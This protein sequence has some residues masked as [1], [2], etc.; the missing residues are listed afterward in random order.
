MIDLT[1]I[2][3]NNLQNRPYFWAE[4]NNLFLPEHAAA[5]AATFPRDH[6]KTVSGY[7]GEKDYEYEARALIDMEK[8][9]IQHPEELTNEWL[10]LAQDLLSSG[11][12]NAI[13]SLT[14]CDLTTAPIEVNVFHYGP[15]ASLGP[16]PD[17]PD[18]LVTHI[19]YF[20]QSWNR[21]DGGCLSILRDDNI[22]SVV[23][24]IEPI[25][26][27][28]AILV[29]ADNSWHAVSRVADSCRSSRRSLTATFYR[30]GSIST[31]WPPGD[32]DQLRR[33]DENY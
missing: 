14:G 23:A 30:R 19:I 31:M 20:N 6:F 9:T 2:T 5:L 17:L 24:E 18:K 16:H 21:Q 26:G 28:S 27:N 11:Y 15:G 10:S 3:L 29:R 4:I 13:S 33:Y 22:A 1:K 8:Q 25:A 12:R 32:S 7:G